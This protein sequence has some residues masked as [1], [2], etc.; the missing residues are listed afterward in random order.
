MEQ[1]LDEF[2]HPASVIRLDGGKD[3]VEGLPQLSNLTQVI[4]RDWCD[5]GFVWQVHGETVRPHCLDVGRPL[6]D[7]GD[8]ETG[9]NHVGSDG[10]SVGTSTQ[11]GNSGVFHL[12]PLRGRLE[13]FVLTVHKG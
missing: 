3:N 5:L 2:G 4:G 7:E 6:F 13:T 12:S 11:H 8:I 1:W 10:C 9:T